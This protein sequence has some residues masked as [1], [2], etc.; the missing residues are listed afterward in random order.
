MI[1]LIRGME[2]SLST[3]FFSRS[4]IRE[5]N[6]SSAFVNTS[7]TASNRIQSRATTN[8]KFSSV[9]PSSL[10][11]RALIA[12]ADRAFYAKP[13]PKPR[14]TSRQILESIFRLKAEGY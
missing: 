6:E 4:S 3:N 1:A 11:P 7:S 8:R 5:R 2:M 9:T 12:E 10:S 13:V 14:R